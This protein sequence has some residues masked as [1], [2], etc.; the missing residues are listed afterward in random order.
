MR[1]PDPPEKF[2]PLPWIGGRRAAPSEQRTIYAAIIPLPGASALQPS[3]F[4]RLSHGKERYIAYVRAALLK[5]FR[6][7]NV[8][9]H[10][11]L[12]HYFLPGITTSSRCASSPIRSCAPPR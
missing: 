2:P 12:G 9:Y 11:M 3:I 5:H 4:D 1:T 7:D 6:D 10:G 8:V